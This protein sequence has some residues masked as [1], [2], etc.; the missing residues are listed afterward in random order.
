M[1]YKQIYIL[2]SFFLLFMRDV[3]TLE[4]LMNFAC[5]VIYNS[6]NFTIFLRTRRLSFW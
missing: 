6:F 3:D 2:N 4:T 5:L 1:K